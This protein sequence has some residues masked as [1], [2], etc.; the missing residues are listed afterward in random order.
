MQ[1]WGGRETLLWGQ[2]SQTPSPGW[3]CHPTGNPNPASPAKLLTKKA[4][5]HGSY[6]HTFAQHRLQQALGW[7]KRRR[8]RF[9]SHFHSTDRIQKGREVIFGLQ[10]SKS[11]MQELCRGSSPCQHACNDQHPEQE[12]SIDRI[13]RRDDTRA[14][15]ACRATRG[16]EPIFPT[17]GHLCR[18]I[19]KLAT[20]DGQNNPV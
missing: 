14:H 2:D 12:D 9:K 18:R 1:S 11:P 5:S 10:L 15:R 17:R 7:E 3:K 20:V 4:N 8:Q 19:C 16:N 13:P 6:L